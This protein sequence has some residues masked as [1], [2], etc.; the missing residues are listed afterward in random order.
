MASSALDS[1]RSMLCSADSGPS[2]S[3]RTR[4]ASSARWAAR[5]PRARLRCAIT[6]RWRSAARFGDCG[7]LLRR[8]PPLAALDGELRTGQRALDA[9]LRGQR[10]FG[11]RQDARRVLRMVGG[12]VAARGAQQERV[13]LRTA[14]LGREFLVHVRR[15]RGIAGTLERLGTLEGWRQLGALGETRTGAQCQRGRCQEHE[16][17]DRAYEHVL[18][19][20][21]LARRMRWG[22]RSQAA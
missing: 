3:A 2:G 19:G 18:K 4:A 1:A 13:A 16:A 6:R 11:Q 21:S 22:R 14:V 20:R 15:A 7:E 5:E 17:D 12:E 8:L 10:A 9:L